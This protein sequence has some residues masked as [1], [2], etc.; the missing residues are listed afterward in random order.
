VVCPQCASDV[1]PG[2]SFC[3]ACGA[4]V[5]QASAP[6]YSQPGVQPGYPVSQPGVQLGQPMAQTMLRGPGAGYGIDPKTGLP[7]S[8]R[9]K[10]VAGVLQICLGGLGVGRF[11]T[12]HTGMAIAQIAVTFVTCGLG[13]FWPLIDGIMILVGESPKD[14]DGKPLRPG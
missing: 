7:Y 1:T 2:S 11:Y 4:R 8:H 12:G 5:S 14:V 3:S 9:S 6:Q 13:A 10:I